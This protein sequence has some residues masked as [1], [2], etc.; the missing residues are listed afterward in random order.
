M[1]PD[2]ELTEEDIQRELS[3]DAVSGPKTFKGL[4]LAKWSIGLRDL[5]WK[6]SGPSDTLEMQCAVGLHILAKAYTD[7]PAQQRAKRMA[8]IKETDD[9]DG[10]RTDVSLWLDTWTDEDHSASIQ[11]IHD[12]Q[13]PAKLA[14]VT[15]A[16]L[17]K[18]SEPDALRE[19]ISLSPPSPDGM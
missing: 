7:D 11:L 17:E 16:G 3:A 8:L 18:K 15:T 6:C 2:T 10:F 14:E 4:P 9:M 5:I 12:I 13:R 1:K 19:T